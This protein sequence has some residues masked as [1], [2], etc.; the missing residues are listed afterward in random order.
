MVSKS[1]AGK[2]NQKEKWY[3]TDFK[4]IELNAQTQVWKKTKSEKYPELKFPAPNNLIPKNFDLIQPPAVTV[5]EKN[6]ALNG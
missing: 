4:Q 1:F 2:T 3:Q 5:S 6:K